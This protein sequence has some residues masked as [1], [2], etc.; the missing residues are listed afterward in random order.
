MAT[1][2]SIKTFKNIPPPQIEEIMGPARGWS[3]PTSHPT[4]SWC[5]TYLPLSG[6]EFYH[7]TLMSTTG[8]RTS[9]MFFIL[10][11]QD[12]LLQK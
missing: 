4:L 7:H 6:T 2:H 8:M 12:G 11:I 5:H 9:H 3:P 1:F 10:R